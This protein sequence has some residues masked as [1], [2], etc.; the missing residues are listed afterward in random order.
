MQRGVFS[1]FLSLPLVSQPTE[2]GIK[3]LAPGPFVVVLLVFS[4]FYIKV[5]RYIQGRTYITVV[6]GDGREHRRNMET[7]SFGI[8]LA[9]RPAP[10]HRKSSTERHQATMQYF[11]SPTDLQARP[12][13]RRRLDVLMAIRVVM[14]ATC[15]PY[16]LPLHAVRKPA[17]LNIR[18]W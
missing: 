18:H 1:F 13:C 16:C 3:A 12:P 14:P 4:V 6:F 11:S 9:S 2:E 8:G 17:L 5:C 7:S 15:N 10:L